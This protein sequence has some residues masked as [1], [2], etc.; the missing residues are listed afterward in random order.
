MILELWPSTGVWATSQIDLKPPPR[1]SA[2]RCAT[3]AV[4][5]P[6]TA[7]HS[8][9]GALQL[10]RSSVPRD[11][12][13]SKHKNYCARRRRD[14]P[15]K[16][17]TRS[18]CRYCDDVKAGTHW[19]ERNK[20]GC[21]HIKGSCIAKVIVPRGKGATA[22]ASLA[23]RRARARALPPP[24]R[25]LHRPSTAGSPR[26]PRIARTCATLRVPR[27]FPCARQG[28]RQRASAWSCDGGSSSC[29][30]SSRRVRGGRSRSIM[31]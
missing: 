1:G 31:A 29:P 16:N 6:L 3:D 8:P 22:P 25:A 28:S 18:R 5:G 4:R 30:T 10:T 12:Q 14:R 20:K 23:D 15:K 24:A 13:H 21:A 19:K 7:Q 9:K 17:R 26:L 2:A 27:S 11:R